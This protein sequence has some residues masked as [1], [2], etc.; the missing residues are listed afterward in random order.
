MDQH[1]K[2]S[3]EGFKEQEKYCRKNNH[4]EGCGC[5]GCPG[6]NNVTR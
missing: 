1:G 4:P 6:E 3:I 5:S 2:I